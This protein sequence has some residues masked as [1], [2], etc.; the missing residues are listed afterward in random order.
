[1]TKNELI[2]KY[3]EL[4]TSLKAYEMLV[5]GDQWDSM[6]TRQGI[7]DFLFREMA[8]DMGYHGKNINN[9]NNKSEDIRE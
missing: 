7:V 3:G 6:E 9:D 5:E 1:M 8:R 4:F 2:Y